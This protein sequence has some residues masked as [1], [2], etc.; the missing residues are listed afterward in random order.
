MGELIVLPLMLFA[1]LIA[2]LAVAVAIVSFFANRLQRSSAATIESAL[3][4]QEKDFREEM[5]ALREEVK[6]LATPA[7]PMPPTV[8]PAPA[9]AARRKITE[10]QLMILGAVLACHFG[11]RVKIRS[12]R[13]ISVGSG[14]NVWSQ[15]GRAAVQAS[16]SG[17]Y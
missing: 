1:V 5:R 10:D 3:A 16:H 14:S 13:V 17:L 15:Q 2:G 7:P 4:R 12:A 8:P 11:K 6:A 9:Q